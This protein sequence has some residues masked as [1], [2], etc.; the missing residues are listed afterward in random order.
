V[1]GLYIG[2]TRSIDIFLN[3]P[4][5]AYDK[6]YRV[7]ARIVHSVQL[8]T[9]SLLGL[10]LMSFLDKR[11]Y[12]STITLTVGG[13]LIGAAVFYIFSLFFSNLL[14]S[15]RSTIPVLRELVS[16]AFLGSL[17]AICFGLIA[18][19]PLWRSGTR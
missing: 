1:D 10:P 8:R 17:A 16:G 11:Q 3:R 18:G 4:A 12:L 7:H 15:P 19:F 6:V 5:S 2:T 14:G 9:S 13:A